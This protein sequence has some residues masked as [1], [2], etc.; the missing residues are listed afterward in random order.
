ML[1]NF[2]SIKLGNL[3]PKR[4]LTYVDD[5]VDGFIKAAE[6]IKSNILGEIINLGTRKTFS[7]RE[8]VNEIKKLTNSTAKI[9]IEKTRIRPS[10]SEVKIL[11]SDNKKARKLINWVPKKTGKKG[12]REGLVKT[13]EFFNKENLKQKTQNYIV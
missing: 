5:T 13:I 7:M 10:K 8:V 9:D 4:D 1:K 3:A 12:L 11:L 2:K 6:T